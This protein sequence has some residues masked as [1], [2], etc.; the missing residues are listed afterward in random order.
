MPFLHPALAVLGETACQIAW[1]TS[2]LSQSYRF[3]GTWDR[4]ALGLLSLFERL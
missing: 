1:R 3:L 4:P 2:K